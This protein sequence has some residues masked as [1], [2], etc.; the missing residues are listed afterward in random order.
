MPTAIKIENVSKLYRLGQVGTG[1]ISHDLNRWWH[2]I[3]GKEDPY[4]K[5]GQRNDR[6]QIA[7]G[8]AKQEDEA[9][10]DLEYVWALK[11]I[12]L[13]V[14]QGE[15]L[16]IIG[17]NGAGKSTLLKLLSRVTAPT[18]GTIKT[19]GRTA[20]L[21]EVGTG[22]HP[23]LTGR[24]NI[25][26]NGAILGM[27][28]PEITTELDAIVEFSGCAKYLDTPVKRYSSGMMVR[29]GFAVAAHLQCEI[30]IVD[31]VLAVGDA[32]FQKKCIGKL[33]DVSQ[34]GRTVLIVSHNMH[35][36]R[37][38]CTR[39]VV[40][41]EGYISRVGSSTDIVEHYVASTDILSSERTWDLPEAPSTDSMRLIRAAVI[42]S[43]SE[44][45]SSVRIDRRIGIE[46]VYDVLQDIER[47]Y[48]GFWLKDS[49]GTEVLSTGNQPH[50][51]STPDP[52]GGRAMQRGRYRS[53]CWFPSDLLNATHYLVSPIL[54]L[55]VS[56]TQVLIEDAITFEVADTSSMRAEYQG[57]WLGVVRPKLSWSTDQL[58][59]GDVA[60]CL[61]EQVTPADNSIS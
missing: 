58:E 35:V 54:G 30:L 19:R 11:D 37:N 8:T 16:G 6:T 4:T 10:S 28:R 14:E 51:S 1:T 36:I 12:D 32:E 17:R 55:G 52:F 40:L 45:S 46:I 29:L 48:A 41:D 61:T 24:E 22:F 18:T 43:D 21:L 39:G 47:G 27:K 60:T 42:N 53:I 23:E 56:T 33:G 50:V 3:R 2:L 34:K 13:E 59:T 25:Y 49:A 31:E 38:L 9:A 44:P 5:V 57:R 15:I 7:G 26:L 20:S